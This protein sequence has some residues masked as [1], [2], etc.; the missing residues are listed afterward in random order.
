MDFLPKSKRER[1]IVVLLLLTLTALLVIGR[2]VFTP[3]SQTVAKDLVDS[4]VTTTMVT[5]V[6]AL[7]L[8]YL[9]LNSKYHLESKMLYPSEIS[10]ELSDAAKIATEW[11]YRGGC[12]RYQR[13][14]VL[15][16]LANSATASGRGRYAYVEILDPDNT[17]LCEKYATYRNNRRSGR[18]AWSADRV[19][20]EVLATIFSA[21][22]YAKT[23]NLEVELYLASGFSLFR[24][25]LSDK[26]AVVTQEDERLPA[27]KLAAESHYYREIQE[28]LRIT[29]STA[30]KLP[31][32]TSRL[33][34]RCR[35]SLNQVAEALGV[36]LQGIQSEKLDELIVM[37]HSP[38]S[39]Y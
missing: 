2:I 9:D 11:E 21:Y 12:G 26:Y 15:P 23:A 16:A 28:D 4:L 35:E 13:F 18:G 22:N 25:D 10:G 37:I 31:I 20:L 39:P 6:L 24:V 14:D 17:E 19:R 1:N 3:D 8:R 7:V 29:R 33:Q 38:A 30:K 36:G 5:L 27:L 32:H 34:V